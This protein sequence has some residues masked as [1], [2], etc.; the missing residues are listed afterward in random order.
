MNTKSGIFTRSF[1]TLENTAFRSDFTSNLV[2]G[3][4]NL[5]YLKYDDINH[6]L[7]NLSSNCDVKSGLSHDFTSYLV[8]GLAFG[9]PKFYIASYDKINHELVILCCNC[10]VTVNCHVTVTTQIN[11]S[12]VCFIVRRNVKFWCFECKFGHISS[13]YVTVGIVVA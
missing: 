7:V 13:V 2:H 5:H 12:V 11:K 1:A 10:D 4:K 6:G 9:T 3:T 8:H